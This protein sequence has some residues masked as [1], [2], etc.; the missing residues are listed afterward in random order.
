MAMALR[1]VVDE[2][3]IGPLYIMEEAVGLV[4]SVV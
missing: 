3:A 4:P 2:I 1:V